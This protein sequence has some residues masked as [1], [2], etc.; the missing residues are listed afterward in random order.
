MRLVCSATISSRD[1]RSAASSSGAFALAR[2]FGF[3]CD[4]DL[5][6]CAI[7]DQPLAAEA[8]GV[9]AEFRDHDIIDGDMDVVNPRPSGPREFAC[10]RD[11]TVA[12]LAG[13]DKG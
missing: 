7:A 4:I 6:L 2:R 8:A 9:A 5:P 3:G 10:R 12:E 1:A 13:F 11:Q